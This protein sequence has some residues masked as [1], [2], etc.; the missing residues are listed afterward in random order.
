MGDAR[1]PCRDQAVDLEERFFSAVFRL[2][3]G[4]RGRAAT[5]D[6]CVEVQSFGRRFGP[7]GFDKKVL[8]V[9]WLP[10]P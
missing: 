5:M 4:A 10:N 1:L 9:D 8:N 6:C 2:K 3:A 7:F